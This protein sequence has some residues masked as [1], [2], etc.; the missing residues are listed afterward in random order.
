MLELSR[1][2]MREDVRGYEKMLELS[3]E[4]GR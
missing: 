2:K 1:E 3:E 4:D